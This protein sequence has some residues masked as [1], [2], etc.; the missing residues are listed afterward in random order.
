MT[1]AALASG[2][3][4]NRDEGSRQQEPVPD[5]AQCTALLTD[6]ESTVGCEG[7]RRPVGDIGPD[8]PELRLREPWWQI[9]GTG[10]SGRKQQ[11]Q[12]QAKE[13]A[14]RII[15]LPEIES[16]GTHSCHT[17]GFRRQA[18]STTVGSAAAI[19]SR[20]SSGPAAF[21]F[22]ASDRICRKWRPPERRAYPKVADHGSGQWS[23]A[24]WTT[25][26]DLECRVPGV[27]CARH[28]G[29]VGRWRVLDPRL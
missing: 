1:I 14:H 29:Q 5:H 13:S 2:I 18:Q 7:H 17:R 9:G 8:A 11:A 24:P 3:H 20:K 4:R 16:R 23:T 22:A 6:E 10:S 12:A 28:G 26:H 15:R 21:S 25:Q 27:L 19:A